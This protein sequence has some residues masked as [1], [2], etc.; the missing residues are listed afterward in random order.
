MI[1]EIKANHP[2]WLAGGIGPQNVREIIDRFKPEFVDASSLL[3]SE[4][5]KKD[6]EKIKNLFKEIKIAKNI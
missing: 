2:L 1:S 4:P 3:E 5:G 6:H